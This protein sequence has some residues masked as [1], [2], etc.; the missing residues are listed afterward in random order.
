MPRG[1]YIRTQE[2][3]DKISK[4]V[5]DNPVKYWLG[6]KR[7][8]F[9]DEWKANLTKNHRK[10][11]SSETRIKISESNKGK[12]MS[13]ESIEKM[14]LSLTGR[15]QSEEQKRKTAERQKGE[16]SHFWRGGITSENNIIR[17]S[18][19]YTL[20]R[21]A[22]FE[23]DNFICQKTGKSGGDLVV[24]H[25]NNFA[26]FKEL[27]FSIDNGITLSK[28]SHKEFHKKYGYKNNTKEQLI[29]FLNN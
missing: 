24:H 8:P 7:E 27:R 20:W 9:S 14:K 19:D 28:K 12:K 2:I 13:V 15:K 18:L 26:E 25:I 17:G 5:K 6:K 16:K 29:E 3:K 23:R 22:C 1:K 4:S 10:T 21:K 11:N